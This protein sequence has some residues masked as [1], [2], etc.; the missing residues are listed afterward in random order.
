[1]DT[2]SKSAGEKNDK[3]A[4][5]WPEMPEQEKVGRKVCLKLQ[6]SIGIA[7]HRML[8]RLLKPDAA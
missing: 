6:V 2:E 7:L 1:M 4:Q 3:T 8:A 5:R